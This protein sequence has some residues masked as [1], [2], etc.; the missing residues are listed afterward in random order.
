MRK[1]GMDFLKEKPGKL[2]R[3]FL[4]ASVGSGAVVS[5]YSIVDMAAIG[6]SEGPLGA[7]A[8]AVILVLFGICTVCGLLCGIGG[9]VFFSSCRGRGEEKEANAY[10]S[11]AVL[12]ILLITA[13]G[14][15]LLWVFRIPIFRAFGARDAATLAKTLEYTD[16]MTAFFPAFVLPTFLA[17]FIRNDGAPDRVLLAVVSGGVVNMFGDWYFV[18]PLGMGMRGAAAA[19]VIGSCV[20]LA[21]MCTHFFSKHNRLRFV[22]PAFVLQ[23]MRRILTAGLSAALLSI[24][25]VIVVTTANNQIQEFGTT[26]HLAVYGVLSSVG[27]LIITMFTG[28]GQAVQPLVSANFGAGLKARLKSFWYLGLTAE[29]VFATTFL[30]LGE[31]FPVQLTALFV[32]DGPEVLTASPPIVRIFFLSYLFTGFNILVIYYLQA[33]L[34]NARAMLV[35]ALRSLV[36]PAMLLLGLPAVLGLQGVWL[37]FPAAEGLTAAAALFCVRPVLRA[38]RCNE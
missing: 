36:L 2:F 12:L 23:K 1:N 9:A 5:V 27:A 31:S 14:W 33:Q 22:R 35:A 4:A 7:A 16:W 37:A 38:G 11:A 19:T 8:M 24:D 6:Q 3:R 20:Q 10:F 29:L 17:A 25:T 26:T 13:A 32:A 18:F 15:I 21:L 28:V 30:V 34:K